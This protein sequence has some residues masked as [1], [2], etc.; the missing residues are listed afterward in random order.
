MLTHKYALCLTLARG[1]L[2]RNARSALLL[3]SKEA[4]NRRLDT[5]LLRCFVE[6]VLATVATAG[7]A[8]LA[9]LQTD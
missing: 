1:V 7:V 9:V 3:L 2:P 6:G 8:T 4:S 5:F